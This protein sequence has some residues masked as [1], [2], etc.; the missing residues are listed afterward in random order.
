MHGDAGIRLGAAVDFGVGFL[1]DGRDHDFEAFC[2]RRIEEQKGKAAIAGNEA[3]F[4]FYL[5]TPR[6]LCSM[7][8]TSRATS[9]PGSVRIF[10]RACVVLS[11]A[12]SST[13]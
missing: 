2:P 8:L 7:K 3:E 6:S 13:R 12:A 5:I 11:L 4:H 10:S 9:S 1:F